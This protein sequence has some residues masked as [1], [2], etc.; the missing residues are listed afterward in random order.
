MVA[1]LLELSLVFL[2]A[3]YTHAQLYTTIIQ[4][5]NFHYL[6]VNFS[7][8]ITHLGWS[9]GIDLGLDSMLF[10][11]GSGRKFEH[12]NIILTILIVLVLEENTY[13]TIFNVIT[14]CNAS[15]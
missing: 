1:F 5:E 8:L 14:Y 2:V 12:T 4:Y 10:L 6:N 15:L 3:C 13:K 11:K 7:S 9:R